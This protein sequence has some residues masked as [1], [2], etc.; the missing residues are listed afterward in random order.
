MKLNDHAHAMHYIP[1]TP[2]LLS[3]TTRGRSYYDP[4]L[5]GEAAEI[6]SGQIICHGLCGRT[7]RPVV[8][9]YSL[10]QGPVVRASH[11]PSH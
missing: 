10:V 5:T 11:A 6:L 2:R 3:T 7:Y 1:R 4:Q 9:L 8:Y